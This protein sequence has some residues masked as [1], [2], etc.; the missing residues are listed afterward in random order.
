MAKEEVADPGGCF[1]LQGG[2]WVRS[3][4]R[5]EEALTPWLL[6]VHTEEAGEVRGA[7]APLAPGGGAGAACQAHSDP[8]TFRP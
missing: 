7:P 4:E 1:G 6:H 3:L 5:K 8:Q 2:V